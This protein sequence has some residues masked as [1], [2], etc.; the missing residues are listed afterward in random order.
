MKLRKMIGVGA[1]VLGL[2]CL[3]FSYYI[4]SSVEAGKEK[5]AHAEKQVG[6]GENLLS[7]SPAAKQLSKG[8]TDSAHEKIKAGKE[9]VNKYS[10]LAR[11]LQIGGFALLVIGGGML[12]L[13]Y[14]KR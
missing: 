2:V 5:I 7:L 9:Q 14:R 12:F 4:K 13:M 6:T 1:M 3:G 8:L 10:M 11:E